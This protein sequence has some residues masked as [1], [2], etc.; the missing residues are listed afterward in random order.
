MYASVSIDLDS[1]SCYRRIYGLEDKFDDNM[2]YEV[3]L[4]RFVELMDTAGLRGTLFV[5]GSD[6][7][8]GDNRRVLRSLAREGFEIANH[9]MNHDYRLTRL[10]PEQIKREVGEAKLKL[11]SATGQQVVGFRAPGYNMNDTLA[12]AIF[13]TGHRY[14]TSVFPCLPYYG[15]KALVLSGMAVT[16]KKS[17]SILGGPQVLAAPTKPYRMGRHYWRRGKGPLWELPI[18]VTPGMRLPFLGSFITLWGEKHFNSYWRMMRHASPVLVLEMHGMDFIDGE[19]DGLDKEL[20]NTQ[21]DIKVPWNKKR[22]LYLRL[23][24]RMAKE[25]KVMTLRKTVNCLESECDG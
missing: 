4:E 12:K 6:L 13:D 10:S 15:A 5:V 23:F 7:D 3:G 9:T 14:D 1:I 24:E 21:P 19:W 17:N 20:L 2:I 16:G 11:E 25:R 18:S 8:S 22:E